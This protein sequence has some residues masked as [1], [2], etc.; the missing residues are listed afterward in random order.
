MSPKEFFDFAETHDAQMVDLKFTDLLGT[1][2]HCSFPIDTWDES[3]FEDG[4]GFDGSSIRGWQAINVSDMLAR[5]DPSTA[6]L[7][8]FFARPTVSVI[9]DIVDPETHEDYSRDPRHV[10]RKATEYLK[11]TGIADICYVGPEPEFFIFDEVRY[12]QN[13]YKGYYEIDSVEGAWNTGRFE[14]PNLGYKPSY[15]G[16]YFP[17]SPTDT[18]HD[19]RG[20]MVYEMQKI[21]I[22]V[23]AH[24]HEVGTGGQAEIDMQY[25]PLLK[26]ADQFQWYKYIIKNVAKRQGKTVTFMAKPIFEDNGSGMHTHMSLWNDGKP[27]FAGDGYAGL[28]DSALHAI[29]GLLKH[30][31]ALLAFAAPTAN[32]YHRLVPGFEAPVNLAMSK[33]NRSASVRIPMY[34]ANPKSKRLEFRCPDPTCNGYLTFSA[35][36]MALIDGIQN[37]I[38]PGQP[39]DRDIYEMRAEELAATE[40]TPASLEEA[41]QALKEDHAFLTRGGVFTDDLIETWIRYKEENEL[42]PLRLRP[43]PYEFFLYYDS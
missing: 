31:R 1:W 34:S 13:Q 19:L 11:E 28:S 12:E 5:P 4:V 43:H 29:G 25:A 10:A 24:H 30:A 36:L 26:M 37:G 17:V 7:D 27:Q 23:E 9:A 14:E 39:L 40:K 38:D 33:R 32:S 6:V 8:P 21:G 20:E 42:E 2:Q 22:V 16:G 41:L 3:T 18:Y 35:M 15:K